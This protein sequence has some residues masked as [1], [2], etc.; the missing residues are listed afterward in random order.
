MVRILC[1]ALRERTAG[2]SWRADSTRGSEPCCR[3][4]RTG[5]RSCRSLARRCRGRE[6]SRARCARVRWSSVP[7]GTGRRVIPSVVSRRST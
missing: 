2:A 5:D 6:S 4:A 1:C 7:P 3:C